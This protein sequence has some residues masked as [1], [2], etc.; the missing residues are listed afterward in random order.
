MFV[1]KTNECY[2]LI[3]KETG[4]VTEFQETFVVDDDYWL[5]V[6]ANFFCMACDNLSGQAIK[7]FTICL[8]YATKDEG[9]GNYIVT[10]NPY[11]KM[12]I[13][14]K[15]IKPNLHKYLAE[16]VNNGLLHR[17][18]RGSYRLNPEVVYCG[19]R[20]S[21]ARLIVKIMNESNS[22]A[23]HEQED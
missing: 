10:G 21:R 13:A 6:Y 9:N 23:S 19:D 15:K 16:L 22:R 20:N 8:K 5:K 11:F 18:E 2:S 14:T 1:R 7:L 12:E 17:I 4:E 3:D